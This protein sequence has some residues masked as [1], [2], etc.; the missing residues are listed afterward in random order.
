[1]N[2]R[3]GSYAAIIGIVDVIVDQGQNT[4]LL[5]CSFHVN[6]VTYLLVCSFHVISLKYVLIDVLKTCNMHPSTYNLVH[7][8]SIPVVAPYAVFFMSRCGP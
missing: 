5:V 4:Y 6:H 7:M 8:P 3:K 2:L 1:M